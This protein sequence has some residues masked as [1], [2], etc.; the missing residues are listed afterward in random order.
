MTVD[1][2]LQDY[3]CD[4]MTDRCSARDSAKALQLLDGE[5]VCS[6]MCCIGCPDRCGYACGLADETIR[7]LRQIAEENKNDDWE[8]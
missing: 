8:P 3:R 1:E 4:Y 5:R 2:L 6:R 7:Q